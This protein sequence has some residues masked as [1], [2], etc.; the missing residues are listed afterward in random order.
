[1]D[2]LDKIEQARSTWPVVMQEMQFWNESSSFHEPLDR[3]KSRFVAVGYYLN[4]KA[5]VSTPDPAAETCAAANGATAVTVTPSGSNGGSGGSSG[6]PPA[7]VAGATIGGVLVGCLAGAAIC[8]LVMAK[9]NRP[10][11]AGPLG[12]DQSSDG[13]QEAAWARKGGSAPQPEIDA[14]QRVEMPAAAH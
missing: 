2:Q 10:V 6:A 4:P 8:L 3:F 7:V 12:V 13:E 14:A 9:R 5:T 1:M 11:S